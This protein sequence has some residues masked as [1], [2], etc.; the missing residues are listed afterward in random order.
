MIMITV[1]E[2]LTLSGLG[3][4][5]GIINTLAG[6]GSNLTIPALMVLGMPADVAN[7]TNRVGVFMQ[8]LVGVKGFHQHKKLPTHDFKA[9]IF[10]LL[11][12][13]LAG[14]LLASY[15]PPALL[16][17]LLLGAML[18]VAT[19]VLVRPNLI[20]PPAGTQPFTVSEKPQAF[21]WLLLAGFYGGF[22][23]AGVGFI[24]ITAFAGVLRYELVTSNAL[25]VLSATCF[26]SIA[27]II[28]IYNDQVRWVPGIIL[29]VGA[30][31][32]AHIGVK[33]ALNISQQS[34]KWFLF[35][36]TLVACLTAIFN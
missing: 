35:V 23:Q 30:M 21:F 27:L 1:T 7:A 3:I 19:I 26:T 14:S 32:G 2:A 29:A 9:I 11:C 28:F 20:A 25:K 12:G 36:M 17:Y 18:A 10:P 13:A 31:I 22:V 33:L 16:K 34:L 15:A 6:G 24:L 8:A 4:I 5:A